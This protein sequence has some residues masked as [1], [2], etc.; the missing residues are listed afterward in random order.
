MADVSATERGQRYFQVMKEKQAESA[1]ERIKKSADVNWQVYSLEEVRALK[2]IL[3]E[4]WVYMDRK[5]W[6]R[7]S[8]ASLSRGEL[9]TLIRIGA[10]LRR[11]AIDGRSAAMRAASILAV[12]P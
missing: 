7:C 4:T 9:E 1:I 8:F 11:N 10:E 3:G 6:E 12:R 2:Q 5:D